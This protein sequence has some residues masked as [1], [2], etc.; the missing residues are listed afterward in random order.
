MVVVKLDVVD[1]GVEDAVLVDVDVNG[2]L[3]VLPAVVVAV[4]VV[5]AEEVEVVVVGEEVVGDAGLYF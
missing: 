3:E 2:F 4:V 5:G 1:V